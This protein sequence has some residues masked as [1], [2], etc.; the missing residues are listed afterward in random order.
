MLCVFMILMI[1]CRDVRREFSDT[2]HE[3]AIVVETV[4]TPSRHQTGLGF[5]A[6]KTGPFGMDFGGDFGLRIGGGMQ[7][8]S[9]T[10]QEKFAVVFKCQH[11]KFIIH[12]K[13]VYEKLKDHTGET[14]VVAYREIYRTT[15][16]MKDDKKEVV[17]RIL[18]DYDFL[19]ATLK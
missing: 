18:M 3:D 17:G 11:G 15:Y 9:T 12:R 8:S 7:I 10:I 19:D 16:V 6:I 13:D 5:T 14:V 2:L 1:G 4:H